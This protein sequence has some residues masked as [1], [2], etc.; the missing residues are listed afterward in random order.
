MFPNGCDRMTRSAPRVSVTVPPS[1]E[2]GGAGEQSDRRVDERLRGEA[3]PGEGFDH[4]SPSARS[5]Q[6]RAEEQIVFARRLE[7]GQ[8]DRERD[9]RPV[10]D[11]VNAGCGTAACAS[12]IGHCRSRTSNVRISSATSTSRSADELLQLAAHRRA[13]VEQRRRV[14]A[15]QP[16][17]CRQRRVGQPLQ[18]AAARRGRCDR[19][20]C[21]PSAAGRPAARRRPSRPDVR[22]TSGATCRVPRSCSAAVRRRSERE[23]CP[24]VRGRGSR[25]A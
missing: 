14:V 6:C 18:D 15:G 5:T 10:P 1:I 17:R 24:Q 2:R 12:V 21:R 16:G 7:A 22:R 4:V 9:L 25:S 13:V 3:E 23:T 19:S 20:A 8:P 11:L